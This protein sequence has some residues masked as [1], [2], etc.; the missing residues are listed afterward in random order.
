MQIDSLGNSSIK[1]EIYSQDKPKQTTHSTPPL[2]NANCYVVVKASS[3]RNFSTLV[4]ILSVD[5]TDTVH[6]PKAVQRGGGGTN[7][8]CV[9]LGESFETKE[10]QSLELDD[11]QIHQN[12]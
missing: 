10:H 3:Q 2:I 9:K 11:R 8:V 12:Y 1:S 6:S 7:A 5:L 4:S